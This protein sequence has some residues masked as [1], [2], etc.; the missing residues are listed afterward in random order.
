M[1]NKAIK[2]DDLNYT[3]LQEFSLDQIKKLHVELSAQQRCESSRLT[4]GCL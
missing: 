1:F 4:I 2:E 3:L